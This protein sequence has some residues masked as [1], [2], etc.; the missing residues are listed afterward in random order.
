MIICGIAA[1]NISDLKGLWLPFLLMAVF[2]GAVTIIYLRIMCKKNLQ[3]YYYDGIFAPC[4]ADDR[5]HR[6][7]AS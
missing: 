6:A 5:H 7:P 2:G 3:G 1:I 4:S